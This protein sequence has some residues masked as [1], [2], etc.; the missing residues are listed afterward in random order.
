MK[1]TDVSWRSKIGFKGPNFKQ[2]LHSN[3]ISISDNVAS[4]TLLLSV[5]TVLLA[6]G[7]IEANPGPTVNLILI[8]K[9][10]DFFIISKN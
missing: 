4:S 1:N 2:Q 9:I 7:N 5:I 6:I 8:L 3:A 10:R